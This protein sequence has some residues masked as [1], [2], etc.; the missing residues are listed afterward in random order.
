MVNR[1]SAEHLDGRFKRLT[2]KHYT[3][4]YVQRCERWGTTANAKTFVL[5]GYGPVGIDPPWSGSL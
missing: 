3:S 2:L 4:G 5:F 1:N